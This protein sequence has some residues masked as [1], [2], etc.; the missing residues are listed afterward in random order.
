MEFCGFYGC[1]SGTDDFIQ[2]LLCKGKTGK[3]FSIHPSAWT[4]MIVAD[5]TYHAGGFFL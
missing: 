3:G 2:I 4:S 1:G 5:V